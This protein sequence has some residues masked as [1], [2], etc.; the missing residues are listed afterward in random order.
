MLNYY[1]I[2]QGS[3][4]KNKDLNLCLLSMSGVLCPLP[5]FM[6]KKTWERSII[7]PV[8]IDEETEAQK[9]SCCSRLS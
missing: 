1:F 5:Q 9:R 7:G 8:F 3:E 6:L 4:V 2:Y